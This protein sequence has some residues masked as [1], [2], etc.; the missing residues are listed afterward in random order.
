VFVP[1]FLVATHCCSAQQLSGTS[2]QVASDASLRRLSPGDV[3]RISVWQQ[4]EYDCEC[5]ISAD[6]SIS[7]PLYRELKVTGIPLPE[8]E[9]RLRTFLARYLATPTFEIEPLFRVVV[10]GEV[11]Q[12][13]VYMVPPGTSVAQVIFR[14]GGPTDRGRLEDVQLIR[15]TGSQKIDLTRPDA[16]PSRVEVR[17]GDQI[18]MG[19]RRSVMQDVIAPSSSILA[20]LASVTAVIIQITRR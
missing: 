7:H 18:V 16:A 6:G 4:K 14:A 9:A 12:P 13:N 19:R 2:P 3:I 17:S 15:E 5:P 1:L 10:A 20:A 11:R 8:V